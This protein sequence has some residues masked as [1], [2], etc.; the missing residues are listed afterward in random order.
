MH[1][2]LT[3]KETAAAGAAGWCLVR[4]YDTQMNRWQACVLPVT[5][6]PAQGAR[7]ALEFVVD[8]AKRGN[9]LCIKA[10]QTITNFNAK[11]KK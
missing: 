5:F 9:A 2:L 8:Q 11:G 4:V 1:D 7:Q 10:L 3:E 6:T